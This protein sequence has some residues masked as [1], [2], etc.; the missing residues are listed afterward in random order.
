MDFENMTV[1]ICIT[2]LFLSSGIS[3]QQWTLDSCLAYTMDSNKSLLS[4]AQSRSVAAVD[5]S[6][7][8]LQLA[9]EVEF[10][11][12]MDCYWRIPI[13]TF[14]AEIAGG[15]PGTFIAVRT[16]T[17]W[18]GSYGLQARMKLFD[19]EAW[20]NIRLSALQQQAAQSEFL[21]F[22]KLLRRNVGIAFYMVQQQQENLGIARK[23]HANCTEIHRLISQQFDR[24]LTDKISLNQSASL[25]KEQEESYLKAESAL[26]NALLD[27]K[28]WMGYPPDSE[29][30]VGD[31]ETILPV[32]HEG[33]SAEL[34]PD[35]EVQKSKIDMARQQYK[36]AIAGLYPMLNLKSGYGQSGF[37]E[38]LRQSDW[39]ASGFVGIG[40]SIPVVSL[41][42]AC[43]PKRQKHLIRQAEY[44]FSA[45][46]ENQRKEYLQKII[47]LDE[48]LKSLQIQHE[49]IELAEENERLSMQ[50]IEQ[51]I[52]DMVQL[53][54]IQQDLTRAQESLTRAQINCLKQYVE[55]QYLQ[56]NE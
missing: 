50:K 11:A 10:A 14:P 55:I 7:A 23:R 45:Y 35:Y 27:L 22:K 13:Q 16:G 1:R 47:L 6:S 21:S 8:W 36:S 39:Y 2:L 5:K 28:F 29:L 17:P 48:A 40:V 30:S 18:M 43:A 32:R 33:F 42:K 4:Q 19:V 51:G 15:E 26:Q 46:L 56:S 44:G 52:I 31:G 3:A 25:L 37:G 20:Q 24:G 54:Q 12:G 49:N 34:L 53:K 9:P 38:K 41:T